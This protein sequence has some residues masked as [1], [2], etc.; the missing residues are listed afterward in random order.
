MKSS[1]H[2]VLLLLLLVLASGACSE[3]TEDEATASEAQAREVGSVD[4]EALDWEE[5]GAEGSIERDGEGQDLNPAE[6]PA[7]DRA[8][9]GVASEPPA[10][11]GE[12]DRDV[13]ARAAAHWNERMLHDEIRFHNPAYNGQAQLQIDNG[14][15]R[16]AALAGAGLSS[17]ECFRGMSLEALDVSGNAVS[18]LSPLSGQPLQM[19]YIED[20]LVEDLTPLRGAPLVTFYASRSRMHTLAG[21]EGAPIEE[22][23]IISTR[24]ADLSALAGAPLKMVWLT[25]CPVT[26]LRPIASQWLVSLTL[27]GTPVSDLSPLASTRLQR[28]HIAETKVLDLSPLAGLPLTRLV[29]TPARIEKGLEAIRSIPTMREIGNRFDD[30]GKTLVAPARFWAAYDTLVA[31][32]QPAAS[33]R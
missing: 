32:D 10:L 23:N 3:R 7:G 9:G 12:A 14:K 16:R 6:V 33:P 18:D 28:L 29:F 11:E 15:L 21:L 31:P 1:A 27:Q 20:T 8:A 25:G 19:L 4:R 17:L 24:V 2:P 5:D 30:S 22:L 13:A 26:D